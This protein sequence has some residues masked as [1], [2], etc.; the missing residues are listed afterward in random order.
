MPTGKDL[1][2]MKW[3]GDKF[4]SWAKRIGDNT[5]RIIDKI[6]N[7]T[8]V[9][10][11]VYKRCMAILSLSKEY[12]TQKLEKACSLPLKRGMSTFQAIHYNMN[13]AI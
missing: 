9:E 11:Q 8:S 1:A 3:N 13:N 6:L 10:Q 2:K 5:F 7:D 12:G 4:R